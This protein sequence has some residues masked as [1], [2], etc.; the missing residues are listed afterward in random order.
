M[1]N[2]NQEGFTLLELLLATALLILVCGAVYGLY[3]NSM[4]VYL[5]VK[6]ASDIVDTKTSA[7]EL[8]GRYFDRWGIGVVSQV[9]SPLCTTC[10]TSEKYITISSSNGCSDVTFYGNLQGFGFVRSLSGTTANL[11]SCR[12]STSASGKVSSGG[13]S[14]CYTVWNNN[15]I[16]NT[17]TGGSVVKEALAGLSPSDADCSQLTSGTTSNATANATLTNVT[18]QAGSIIQRSPYAIRLYCAS[19]S[20]DGGRNWLYTDLTDQSTC[21]DTAT[22][23]PVAP[24]NNFQVVALPSTTSTNCTSTGG[25]DCGAATVTVT[26]R[27]QS[28]MAAGQF[29]TYTVQRQFGKE[30]P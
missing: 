30:I 21:S 14:N 18:V 3:V 19:N 2:R 20:Q 16:M 28:A 22:A 29:D 8:V 1:M 13:S 27:S 11:I 10:P 5:N 23:L 25:T 9:D 26:F 6:S 7:I 12:L 15:T 24:V 4:A 17:I